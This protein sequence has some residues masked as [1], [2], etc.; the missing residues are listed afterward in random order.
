MEPVLPSVPIKHTSKHTLIDKLTNTKN[1]LDDMR[2]ADDKDQFEF[3]RQVVIELIPE[4]IKT[5][6]M[7]VVDR[8]NNTADFFYKKP[9]LVEQL[10]G[11]KAIKLKKAM[12][13]VQQL[14]FDNKVCVQIK[15]LKVFQQQRGS[16]SHPSQM[17]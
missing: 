13:E 12:H 10:R 9:R 4:A 16:A 15:H 2:V 11:N 14:T 17:G 6:D 8:Y 7:L 3:F 5:P 1:D